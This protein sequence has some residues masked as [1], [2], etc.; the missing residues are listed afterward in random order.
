M[1][2]SE[3]LTRLRTRSDFFQ[4]R[5][6][7]LVTREPPPPP[8]LV[9][10]QPPFI[11]SN[12][13]EGV[14]VLLAVWAD[15][16]ALG[17]NGHVDLGTGIRTALGQI[18]AEELELDPAQVDMVL[19]D[20]GRAPNQGPTIASA[21]IQISAVPLRQAA[22]Q[23]R[24]WLLAE[25]ARRL[26][27]PIDGLRMVAGRVDA[28]A[29]PGHGLTWG[30][31]L[32]GR[33][34][35]LR[36]DAD[37]PLKP[38]ADYRVVGQSAPRVDIPAKVLGEDSF[39]HDVRVP[40]MLHGRVVRPP[41]AGADHGEFIGNT[42]E[43]V[44]ER[45]IAHIAG[46]RAVVV[47]RDFVGVV[48]EREE[49]AE[50]AAAALVVRW[51]PWPGMPPVG[52]VAQ[53][54]RNNP[55]T[56]RQ[57][58]DEGDVDRALAGASQVL[59]RQYVWPYQMHA[60]IGPSCA[61]A[62]WRGPGQQPAL[63]VWAGSQ[64]PHAL[65]ADLSRL[66]GV[67]DVAVDVVR[68]EASGCYGRNCADDV[69]ADAALLSRAVGAPVRVQLTREQEHL[70]EPKGAAQLM[71]VRGGV[72]AD[73]AMAGYDFRSS[74]PS[75]AAPTLAL[76]LT[77]TIE[78][79]PQAFAMGDRTA[80][81]PYDIADLRI[82]INDMPP[83]LRAAWLRGVSALP[84][85]FA[86]ESYIDELAT[87]AGEDP[88][89]YRLRH[90][91]DPRASELLQATAARAGWQAHTAPQGLGATG[92]WQHGQGVAYA[93]YVHSKWPGFGAAW[94]AWVADVDVNRTTGE[95][96]VKRVV[97][98][99]DAGLVINPAGVEHQVHG[100]VLQTTS[101][102]LKEQLRI[103]VET[104][105]PASREWGSYPI[106]SFREV[107]VIEVMQMPR[108]DQPPLGVGESSS[109]PGTAAIANA[110]FDATGVRFRQP[111]FTPEV[112]RAALNPTGLPPTSPAPAAPPALPQPP[113]D[114]PWPRPRS[115]WLKTGSLA[116]GAFGVLLGLLGWRST[117]APVA[118]ATATV[119][120][121]Q[122][123]ERG[124]Q[125]AALGNCAQCH[126]AD[127]RQPLA[128][129]LA[130][131][132]P[133]G[134]VHS[135]N[136]TP[137]AQTGIG[138]WS[139]SAFQR[140]MREGIA[141]DGHHLYPAF[142]YTAY[143]RMTDEDL[144]AL[145]AWLMSQ[146]PVRA[147]TASTR[148]PFPFS[149]RPLLA[150]WNALYLDSGPR[151][152]TE[153]T[154]SEL[155]QRGEYLVNGVG[156]CGA[157]HTPRNALGAEQG[158]AAFLSG[159]MVK[160]WEAPSLTARHPGPVPW[161]EQALF[162][163]LRQGHSAGH[164]AAGGP[165]AEVVRNLQDVP[166]ADVRAMAH[167]L[168]SFGS[169]ATPQQ[170]EQAAAAAIDQAAQAAPALLGPAQRLFEQACAACHHDGQ[171]PRLLGVNVPLALN[172][173]LHSDRPDNLLRTILE[174]VQDPATRTIGF[175]PAFSQAFDDRQLI[176]L[177]GYM[178]AR[179]APQRPAW[180]EL[181]AA[182]ARVRAASGG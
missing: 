128:G 132:T 118:P 74:Y 46:I 90:L 3:R 103:D 11:A 68:L 66:L 13:D 141:R 10:G 145:Y 167:Y 81:P 21:S 156:H 160:G 125:L 116:L 98:G 94:A 111:P 42:L 83:I 45:S 39:V 73:G 100:N 157:C 41:Y 155:W 31:L 50:Q 120:T 152:T 175:M 117:I 38:V 27:R 122:T 5:D 52:D 144:T 34:I 82:T 102:A 119:Y 108:P 99:H 150:G 130:M 179:F 165:M 147:E 28:D 104:N 33:C 89:A 95:V 136:I 126:T 166:E 19:G 164:G 87:A 61:V 162:D 138:A 92:D 161:T 113:A 131:D 110:I 71:E 159:A 77:R 56:P 158:G 169:G 32:H 173:N 63:R 36:L 48:A 67:A 177:A 2:R 151:Q 62:D 139:F 85:S 17:L 182:V 6:V 72:K 97:V 142:P 79:G 124:R 121:A 181:P 109:V 16:T 134:T 148:L 153:R 170:A 168:A 140:A 86:H 47:I 114:A 180:T 129:G 18:V 22:A 37:S 14:E 163:Y 49:Q 80:R 12:P 29:E 149:L 25:A 30:E 106:L 43:A 135:T 4:A 133:F 123:I 171:G 26:A 51:K 20:T 112:V 143:T 54:L 178:R 84:N 107:P 88:V 115:A 75:N 55:A 101:R 9:P 174:G 69:A 146:P 40:G 1:N 59:Q 57:V 137:D 7:L 35:E 58:V 93:R 154:R 127:E 91:G 172:S 105:L 23:A 44:D 8:P 60:S 15:G 53:A 65:R 76:L 78:P 176:E 64:H 96:H 24:A 70:W